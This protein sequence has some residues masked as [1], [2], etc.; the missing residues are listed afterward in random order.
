MSKS[1]EVTLNG[2]PTLDRYHLAEEGLVPSDPADPRITENTRATPH[3]L[4]SSYGRQ[5]SD[6]IHHHHA[7]DEK[8]EDLPKRDSIATEVELPETKEGGP[9][10]VRANQSLSHSF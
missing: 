9:I 1:E 7:D 3:E 4:D 6:Y 5:F 10:Y 2:S 8:T